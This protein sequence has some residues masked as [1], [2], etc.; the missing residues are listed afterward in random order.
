[1]TYTCN[2]QKDYVKYFKFH[3]IIQL[4]YKIIKVRIKRAVI[5]QYELYMLN[6]ISK[7]GCV[8]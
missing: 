5:L 3:S 7:F 4:N 1:M 2:G 6:Y 8:D